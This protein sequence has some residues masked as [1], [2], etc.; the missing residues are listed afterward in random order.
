M[1]ITGIILAGGQNTRMGTD[2]ALIQFNGKTLLENAIEICRPVCQT[3]IISSNNSD[4]ENFGYQIIPD[5]IKNCGPLGGIYSCLKKSD[6]D[7]NVVISV[8][9]AFVTSDFI[10]FLISAIGDFDAI[11]PY[12]SIA[13]EPLI[14]L[15]RKECLPEMEKML[16]NGKYKMQHLLENIKPK[17]VDSDIWLEK[18]PGL[19]TNLNRPEDFITEP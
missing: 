5:E 15:Y 3:I 13:K 7:W 9:S 8:D 10:E 4:H 17:F 1:Q 14:G 6:T 16:V 11:I 18:Y 19:F 12:H 2:K